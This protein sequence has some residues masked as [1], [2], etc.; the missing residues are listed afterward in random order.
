[1][2]RFYLGGILLCVTTFF[3]MSVMSVYQTRLTQRLNGLKLFILID[4][5][6]QMQELLNYIQ[7]N[8]MALVEIESL[9][10][11][12]LKTVGMVCTLKSESKM[13]HRLM[14]GLI[15]SYRGVQHAEEI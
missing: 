6:V 7:H 9:E 8:D 3:T 2:G 12:P 13:N 4:N 14:I 1:L 10:E 15:A 11:M 5:T